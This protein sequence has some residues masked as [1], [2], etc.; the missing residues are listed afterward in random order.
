MKTTVPVAPDEARASEPLIVVPCLNE[1]A[2]I[3]T[4]LAQLRRTIARVGGR[5]V[6]VDGGSTDGTFDIAA[7]HANLCPRVHL[8]RNPQRIQSIGINMAVERFGDMATHLIRI[9]SH[10]GYPEDFCDLLLQDAR[11]VYADCIVVGMVAQGNNRIQRINATVQNSFIGNGG[12]RHRVHP[13]A[14]YVDHGHHALIKLAAFRAVGG[15]DPSF[16]HNEDAELDYRLRRAGYRIW[17][18]SKT[19]VTYYP[20]D[21]L[22]ALARQYFN[23]GK[24]R[25]S[26]LIKHRIIPGLR[27]AKV[28]LVLP[29]VLVAG[30][31]GFSVAFAVPALIWV[32]ACL[33]AGVAMVIRTRQPDLVISGISAMLM[34]FSWSLGFWQRVISRLPT[35]LVERAS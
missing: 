6:V 8:M 9:D 25:A 4:L 35:L 19:V 13:L 14:G 5:I 21:T 12:S 20:R 33:G 1:A 10:C 32:S 28:V 7:K 29:A 34:H 17:L 23:H 30:L 18:T 26:N 24:G 2:H 3:G 15:Y 31:S 11:S 16:T 22:H 27:Q